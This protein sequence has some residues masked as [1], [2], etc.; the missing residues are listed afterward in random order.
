MPDLPQI[1]PEMVEAYWRLKEQSNK[2]GYIAKPPVWDLLLSMA[3]AMGDTDWPDYSAFN[4]LWIEPTTNALKPDETVI[5]R[6]EKCHY[7]QSNDTQCIN[8]GTCLV[9]AWD[10]S[11][12]TEDMC[13]RCDR[14]REYWIK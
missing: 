5:E 13:P 9:C 10:G 11:P 3:K 2:P 7:P 12:G 6:C 4:R 14:R 1:T 8:C